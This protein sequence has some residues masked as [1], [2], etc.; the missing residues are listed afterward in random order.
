MADHMPCPHCGGALNLDVIAK[1]KE[2]S[3]ICFELTPAPGELF[4][5]K[6]VGESIAA[7]ADLLKAAGREQKVPVEVLVER[8][9]TGDDGKISVRMLIA[10]GH[11]H[12]NSRR[13]RKARFATGDT[14]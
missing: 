14:P 7:M 8:I 3:S 13:S 1:L 11:E 9:E 4:S 10:R 6:N 12:H 5:A 2:E